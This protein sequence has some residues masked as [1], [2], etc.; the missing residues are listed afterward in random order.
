MM[1]VNGGF[2]QTRRVFED[3]L[4]DGLLPCPLRQLQCPYLGVRL[5]QL[6]ILI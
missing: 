3:Y 6:P 5:A 1:N 4:L 2:A